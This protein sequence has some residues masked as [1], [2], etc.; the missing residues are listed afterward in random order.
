MSLKLTIS[1]L[2]NILYICH[3]QSTDLCVIDFRA[4]QCCSAWK[5]KEGKP[6]WVLQAPI[7]ELLLS[8]QYSSCSF[9][10]KCSKYVHIYRNGPGRNR[11]FLGAK[12]RKVGHMN[13]L[14]VFLYIVCVFACACVI[15]ILS[16][17]TV[18]MLRSEC[19]MSVSQASW[20]NDFW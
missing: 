11:N 1:F 10:V 4:S 7:H 14:S 2:Y 9:W 12:K 19:G 13:V 20:L 8:S 6:F 17:L 5:K 16:T 18:R 3:Y 15:Y